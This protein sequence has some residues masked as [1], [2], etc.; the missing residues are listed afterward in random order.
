MRL[1]GSSEEDI[2]GAE[3]APVWTTLLALA[4]TLR[5]DA[6]C[7]GDGPPPAERLAAVTQPVLLMTGARVDP[8]LGPIVAAF[9][10]DP[11]KVTSLSAST[12]G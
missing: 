1:A 12:G 9:Y 3:A 10:T 11:W 4:P 8:L 6:A 7:L 2:A 5:Y